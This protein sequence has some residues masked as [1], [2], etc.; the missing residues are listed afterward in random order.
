[1]GRDLDEVMRD[2]WIKAGMSTEQADAAVADSRRNRK[3]L[4]ASNAVVP[5]T[6]LV[7]SRAVEDAL[8]K[9]CPLI[10][11]HA[12]AVAAALAAVAIQTTPGQSATELRDGALGKLASAISAAIPSSPTIFDMVAREH[13]EA[14]GSPYR[15]YQAVSVIDEVVEAIVE[16]G[17][18]DG[19][20]EAARAV[21]TIADESRTWSKAL[22]RRRGRPTKPGV[23]GALALSA[24][25]FKPAQVAIVLDRQG[26]TLDGYTPAEAARQAAKTRRRRTGT[27]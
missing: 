12:D 17:T 14:K 5:A 8:R 2:E 21:K 1:M 4:A 13:P 26:L 24:K 23:D 9:A 25:G 10:A 20:L 3:W 27:K 22:G 19:V 6:L 15:W 18:A 16:G 11:G 7:K